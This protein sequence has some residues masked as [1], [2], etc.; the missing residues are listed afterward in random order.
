MH[1]YDDGPIDL[2]LQAQIEKA[3]AYIHAVHSGQHQ[4]SPE[5]RKIAHDITTFYN[6]AIED[7]RERPW[8]KTKVLFPIIGGPTFSVEEYIATLLASLDTHPIFR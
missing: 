1:D 6:Q 2:G 4:E 8:L 3:R 5:R 7:A